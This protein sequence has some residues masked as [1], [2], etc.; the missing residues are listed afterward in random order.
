MNENKIH[1]IYRSGNSMTGIQVAAYQVWNPLVKK[2]ARTIEVAQA[3]TLEKWKK[4]GYKYRPLYAFCV[5]E[6]TKKLD[7]LKE[8]YEEISKLKDNIAIIE[9]MRKENG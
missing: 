1:E 3:G 4:E 5:D 7:A 9:S 8:A 2:W 6:D